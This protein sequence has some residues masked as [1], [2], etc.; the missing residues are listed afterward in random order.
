M[1]NKTRVSL[2]PLDVCT[3]MA[4]ETVSML[5]AAPDPL[6]SAAELRSAMTAFAVVR[7]LGKEGA[8]LLAWVDA[9]I[10]SAKRFAESGEDSPHL[11]DPDRLLAVPDAA[12]QL[13]VVW[14]LF[15]TAIK[16]ECTPQERTLLWNAAITLTEIGGLDDLILT[17]TP[18]MVSSRANALRE[19]LTEV[20][21][22]LEI[23][24]E[25]PV[26]PAVQQTVQ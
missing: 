22:A 17:A 3:L 23:D 7:G 5:D 25:P 14:M 20:R 9:E 19:E 26:A 18:S 11:V 8:P 2:T 16:E 6:K 13:E 15:G 12:E 10:D 4:C 24:A 1:E 21:A